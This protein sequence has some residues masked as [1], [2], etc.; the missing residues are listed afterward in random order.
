[1]AESLAVQAHALSQDLTAARGE[2]A[3]LSQAYSDQ[4][5]ELHKAQR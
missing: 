1:M 5:R 3:A 4:E 2:V